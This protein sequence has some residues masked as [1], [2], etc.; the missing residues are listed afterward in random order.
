MDIV[1]VLTEHT[2]KAETQTGNRFF[3]A[4]KRQQER[5]KQT[6]TQTAKPPTKTAHNAQETP[7]NPQQ[8][9]AVV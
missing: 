5:Q 8:Q 4:H 7:Q 2:T 9:I 6:P 1:E 3:D